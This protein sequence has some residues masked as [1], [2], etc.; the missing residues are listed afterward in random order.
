[1]LNPKHSLFGNFN[2][3]LRRLNYELILVIGIFVVKSIY[4]YFTGSRSKTAHYT[5]HSGVSFRHFFLLKVLIKIINNIVF[6]TTT[7]ENNLRLIENVFRKALSTY[8]C[9]ST[10]VLV[11]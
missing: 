7:Q 1:M 5:A 8:T 11:T 3:I 4:K 6:Q 2:L 9:M 10:L